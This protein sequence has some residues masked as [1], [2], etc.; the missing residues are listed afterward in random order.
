MN[1]E[2]IEYTPQSIRLRVEEL[3]LAME[4]RT[5]IARQLRVKDD[6][7]AELVRMIRKILPEKDYKIFKARVVDKVTLAD[8]GKEHNITRERTR[9][10]E[11]NIKRRLIRI[12]Y[13][14]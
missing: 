10:I 2:N 9:Q 7:I 12:V 14:P 8:V 6:R 1:N 13:Q 3:L 11:E 4:A 5:D